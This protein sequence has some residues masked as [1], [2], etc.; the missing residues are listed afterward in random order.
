MVSNLQNE[1]LALWYSACLWAAGKQ[2]EVITL[3]Y[4]SDKLWFNSAIVHD[5]EMQEHKVLCPFFPP[6]QYSFKEHCAG[7]SKL[8]EEWLQHWVF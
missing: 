3:A 4:F 7:M 5:T 2:T 8:L 1:P 6:N